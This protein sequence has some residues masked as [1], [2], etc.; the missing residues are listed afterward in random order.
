MPRFYFDLLDGERFSE[1]VDGLEFDAL[2]TA[3]KEAAETL[4]A[5]TKDATPDCDQRTTAMRIRGEG[6]ER[7]S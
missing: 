6:G 5:M 7:S 1:D 4:G 2:E 3:C